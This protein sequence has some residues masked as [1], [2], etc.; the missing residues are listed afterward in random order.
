MAQVVSCQTLTVEV[1]SHGSVHVGLV[2]DKLAQGQIVHLSFSAIPPGLHT[3]NN[4][5]YARWWPQFRDIVPPHR[6]ETYSVQHIITLGSDLCERL[7][8]ICQG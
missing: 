6:Q 3:H 5:Q 4:E 8:C 7:V 2:V 1:S